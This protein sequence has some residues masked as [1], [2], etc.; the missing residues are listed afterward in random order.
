MIIGINESKTLSIYHANV[1]VDLIEE[2]VNQING[3]IR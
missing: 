2:N 3:G 1:K